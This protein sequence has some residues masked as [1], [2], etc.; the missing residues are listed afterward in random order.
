M[1][2]K[3]TIIALISSL[4][5]LS[6]CSKD[7][8]R[9]YEDR[10]EGGTWTLDKVIEVGFPESSI[11]ILRGSYTF[12]GDGAMIYEDRYGGFFEGDWTIRKFYSDQC[13]IDDWGNSVCDSDMWRELTIFAVDYYTKERIRILFDDI[14]FVGTNTFKAY[15]YDRRGSYIF[16]FRR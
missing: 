12:Y 7:I 2:N 1:K 16:T 6:S 11:S 15:I 14:R 13:Y 8:L 9:P 10:L 3:F 4:I 5:F